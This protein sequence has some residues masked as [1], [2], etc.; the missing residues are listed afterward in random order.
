MQTAQGKWVGR[1]IWAS[2]IQGLIA[3]AVTV[4]IID[5]TTLFSGSGMYYS[6]SRVIA[7]NGA[8]TWLF[9]GYISYLV[10]GVVAMAVTAIFY[11]YIE[12]LKGKVYKGIANYLAWGHLVFMNVG[13]A[14]SMLLMMWGGYLAGWAA[15]PASSGGGGETSLQIHETILGQLTYPIGAFVLLAALGALLGGLGYIMSTRKK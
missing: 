6:A 7:G 3:V 15:T 12:D 14:V 9:V 5:P 13:I 8:G 2:V 11:F 1:F 10:V 4:L